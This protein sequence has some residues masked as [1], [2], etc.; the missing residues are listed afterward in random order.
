MGLIKW[1]PL[2]EMEA[3]VDRAIG[4]PFPRLGTTGLALA[5]F[6]PRVDI[7]ESDGSY[8][9]KADLPGMNKQDV[10]VSLAGDR[11]TIQGERK[12]EHEENKP[13]YHR[14]E[15]SYGSFSRSFSLPDDADL[16]A[17]NAHCE[18]G[19]LTISIAKKAGA[20]SADAVTVPVD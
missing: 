12:R 4:W 2:T 9:F 15:R 5:E 14:V 10:S 19:E 8:L 11:L 6:G 13:H 18:N 16:H 7:C 1:E 20:P 17:I 3:M